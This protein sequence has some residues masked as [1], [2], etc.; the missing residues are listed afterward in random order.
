ME[1]IILITE[2]ELKSI[3]TN[4]VTD[5]LVKYLPK[6]ETS[7]MPNEYISISDLDISQ[8]LYNCLKNNDIKIIGDVLKYS[9]YDLVKFKNIGKRTIEELKYVLKKYNFEL[10][11]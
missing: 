2:T 11:K 9:E 5:C 1:K 6:L 3:I 8:R 4:C 7:N 10:K